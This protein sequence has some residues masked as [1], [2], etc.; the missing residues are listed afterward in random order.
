[1]FNYSEH[2]RTDPI[3]YNANL[4]KIRINLRTYMRSL[5]VGR[6]LGE[7]ILD[8]CIELFRHWLNTGE[9][10]DEKDEHMAMSRCRSLIKSRVCERGYNNSPI[11]GGNQTLCWVCQ[12]AMPKI[13]NARYVCGCEWSIKRKPVPGWRATERTLE[14]RTTYK[15]IECPKFKRSRASKEEV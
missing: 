6:N 10:R 9:I 13:V 4:T 15:V 14:D 11:E 3:V 5:K 1:M 12:N 8:E 2:K 7:D